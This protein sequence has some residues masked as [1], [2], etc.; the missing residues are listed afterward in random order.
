MYENQAMLAG[1]GT[2][3]LHERELLG[4]G[5]AS[6]PTSPARAD[7]DVSPM[8]REFNA[9]SQ[10]NHHLRQHV[11]QL[12]E[13]L[14]ETGAIGYPTPEKEGRGDRSEVSGE[15]VLV[16]LLAHEVRRVL[17]SAQLV[18]DMTRRLVL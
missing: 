12:G 16:E 4:A 10:A 1:T 17:D 9:L 2:P 7:R 8:Q 14:A 15:S 5:R 13:R 18:A 11:E 3:R 6:N